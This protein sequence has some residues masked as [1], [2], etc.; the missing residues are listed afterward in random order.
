MFSVEILPSSDVC[1]EK[2]LNSQHT[3]FQNQ[4]FS[5]RMNE[6]SKTD[7]ELTA[8]IVIAMIQSV[9]EKFGK[10][11]TADLDNSKILELIDDVYQKLHSFKDDQQTKTSETSM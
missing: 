5:E 4:F 8:E 3:L 9:P 10:G 1:I 7:K 2:S 6:M 11:R